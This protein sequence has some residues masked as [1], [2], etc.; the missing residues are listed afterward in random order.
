MRQARRGIERG[1]PGSLGRKSGGI[2]IAAT[3]AS[4][5]LMVV[6]A[7]S[8]G[9]AERES[10][11]S[12]GVRGL[13]A[14]GERAVE[15]TTLPAVKAGTRGTL[16]FAT[17][18]VLDEYGFAPGDVAA[19]ATVVSRPPIGHLGIERP[20][21]VVR[22][23]HMLPIDG[24]KGRPASP[25]PA[26]PTVDA[27]PPR[28][29]SPYGGVS[30]ASLARF[31][32]A[33]LPGRLADPALRDVWHLGLDLERRDLLLESARYYEQIV[34]EVPEEAYTYWRIARNYWRVGEGR[35][36]EQAEM[37][38]AV[39]VERLHYFELAEQ[40]ASRGLSIDAECAPCML[41]KFVSMGRQATTRGL[42]SAMK[43]AREMDWLLRR[44]IEL[45]PTHQDFE[46]NN[47]LGNLYYAG[48]VFYRVVPDWFWMRWVA[49]VRGDKARSLSY[50]RRAVELS[51]IRVD[52][53]VELGASLLCYGT[54]NRD[55]EAIIEGKA[56][57]KRA[58]GLDDYLPTDHLDKSHARILIDQPELAC[59]YSRDG[60]I[61]V[62]DVMS[63]VH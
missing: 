41:W 58:Q 23:P 42:L 39:K 21:A 13:R 56:V 40:W 36:N 55:D 16:S 19:P 60:F 50:A 61:D 46:G 2:W 28:A 22:P 25:E 18:A 31:D 6:G 14:A 12:R 9:A 26:L 54:S 7:A 62:E 35:G 33:S 45:E 27:P 57:L 47:T 49:G 20:L 24:P 17:L 1:V 32:Y 10:D 29:V 59:G 63:E 37:P 38:E 44:G 34:S 4:F 3:G 48:S 53:R 52:Y 30:A 5:L 43:D 8:T 15:A 11:A 51:A